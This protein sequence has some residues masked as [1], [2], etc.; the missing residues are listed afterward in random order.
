MV[1]SAMEKSEAEEWRVGTVILEG[2]IREG[3]IVKV[4]C[5]R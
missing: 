2:M 3:L 4:K 5:K 1:V